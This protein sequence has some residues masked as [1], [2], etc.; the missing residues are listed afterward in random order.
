MEGAFN[1]VA[2]ITD[3]VLYEVLAQDAADPAV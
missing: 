3:Q 1:T 2:A